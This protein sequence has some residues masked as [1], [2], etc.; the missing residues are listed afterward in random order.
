[1]LTLWKDNQRL[2]EVQ[3]EAEARSKDANRQVAMAIRDQSTKTLFECKHFCASSC[4]L[5]KLSVI[6]DYLLEDTT[7]DSH[8][9]I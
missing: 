9:M 6:A 5:T 1:M 3:T 4:S 7:I 8:C 2:A